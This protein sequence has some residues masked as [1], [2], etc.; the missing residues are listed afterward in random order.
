[1]GW[2]GGRIHL[3]AISPTSVRYLRIQVVSGVGTVA[4]SKP[5]K[6]GLWQSVASLQRPIA[7][8]LFF[9]RSF[10]KQMAVG[11]HQWYHFW[12]CTTHV[13]TYF[14]GGWDVHWGYDLG[15]DPW[16]SH[17]NRLEVRREAYLAAEGG[18]SKMVVTGVGRF[19][20]APSLFVSLFCETS[21]WRSFGIDQI[22]LKWPWVTTYASILGRM[23]THVTTYFDDHQGYRV[24]THSQMWIA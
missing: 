20:Q 15:F 7:V 23:N 8:S 9:L 18:E 24:L 22:F 11:Q 17:A 3:R 2:R 5:F 10:P 13:R 19:F 4:C 16:P 6:P 12:G 1:M 21:E 14:S